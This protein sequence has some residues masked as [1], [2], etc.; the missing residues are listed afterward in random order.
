MF[1]KALFFWGLGMWAGVGST[2]AHAVQAPLPE[3]SQDTRIRYVDYVPKSVTALQVYPGFVVHLVFDK[4]EKVRRAYTGAQ[5]H[6][7]LKFADNGL[8]VRMRQPQMATNLVVQTQNHTYYFDLVPQTNP[9]QL[10]PGERN[11]NPRLVY[12]VS[13]RDH[14]RTVS[15]W[16]KEQAERKQADRHVAAGGAPALNAPTTPASPATSSSTPKTAGAK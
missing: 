9:P 4:G 5:G 15:A 3:G 8:L 11:R 14:Q 16:Q 2:L 10:K 6:Y 1:I 12:R 13:M 7:W